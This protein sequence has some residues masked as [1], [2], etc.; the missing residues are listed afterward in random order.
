VASSYSHL[1]KAY[2]A[3]GEAK[4]AL[5]YYKKGLA[6]D[7]KVYGEEHP[8]VAISYSLLGNAYKALGDAKEA[9]VYYKKGLAIQLKVYGEEHPSVAIS[10]ENLG[11]LY[12]DK[13]KDN[14]E[15]KT[16]LEKALVIYQKFDRQND[17][18]E[19]RDRLKNLSRRSSL[20][21]SGLTAYPGTLLAHRPT[22]GVKENKNALPPTRS[23]C[24]VM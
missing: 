15:A 1:G 3:L 7:L 6:I 22:A 16:C 10:Y 9:L 18:R 11:A 21:S 13:L 24:R 4:E 5:V 14:K 20:P 8:E 12:Q 23:Q 19:V 2:E 17:I